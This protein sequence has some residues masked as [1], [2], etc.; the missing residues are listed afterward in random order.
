[1]QL[2]SVGN[3]ACAKPPQRKKGLDIAGNA[4]VIKYVVKTVA[5]KWLVGK[6]RLFV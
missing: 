3:I 5:I 6:L 4:F 1:M 2:N